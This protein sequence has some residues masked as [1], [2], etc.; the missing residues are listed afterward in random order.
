MR[1][2]SLLLTEVYLG[3]RCKPCREL[4]GRGERCRI[5]VRARI[6]FRD[7]GLDPKGPVAGTDGGTTT[8]L[9]EFR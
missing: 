4:W 6:F 1:P 9:R 7:L 5:L 2:E 3:G 8:A